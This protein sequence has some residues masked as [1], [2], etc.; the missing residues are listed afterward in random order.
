LI[1]RSNLSK[2]AVI[3]LGNADDFLLDPIQYIVSELLY[4]FYEEIHGN[5]IIKTLHQ[6]LIEYGEQKDIP[7]IKKWEK[8]L[9][10]I[11]LLQN[12]CDRKGKEIIFICDTFNRL[13][14]SK[15]LIINILSLFEKISSKT[16][17]ITT[18]TDHQT[19]IEELKREDTTSITVINLNEANNPLPKEELIEVIKYLFGNKSNNYQFNFAEEILDILNE[20]LTL[21]FSFSKY[22]FAHGTHFDRG[23]KVLQS[24][25]DFKSN[26]KREILRAHIKWITENNF[27]E[28]KRP[29]QECTDLISILDLDMNITNY[30]LGL[31]KYLDLRYAY[32]DND[33]IKS[34][35]HFVTEAL[36]NYYLTD[37]I[38]EQFM[39]QYSY[40]MTGSAFGGLFELYMLLKLKKL[41]NNDLVIETISG[42]NIIMLPIEFSK[43]KYGKMNSKD[44]KIKEEKGIDTYKIITFEKISEK[45]IIYETPQ[46]NFPGFDFVYHDPM[47]KSTVWISCK[48]AERNIN[49]AAVEPIIKYWQTYFDQAQK[50]IGKLIIF[51]FNII[52]LGSENHKI[53]ILTYGK[54]ESNKN[55]GLFP[56]EL[57]DKKKIL[58]A[59]YGALQK[60]YPNEFKLKENL[61]CRTDDK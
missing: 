32:F 31:E 49:A 26:Y 4:W 17:Y 13:P 12:E 57:T 33:K 42:D 22:C 43:L 51:C 14:Q 2:N 19:R 58:F 50:Q 9:T 27:I 40:N 29:I 3:Y 18:N 55:A 61:H 52:I 46:Q 20:N 25:E 11:S 36:R 7:D 60:K 16:I 15:E 38:I 10:I 30:H 6:Y 21:I 23:E 47:D 39:N 5:P 24:I 53:L 45:K 1:Y 28:N 37:E 54:I 44:P 59:S 41:K 48:L 34:I 8:L 56:R 35:N